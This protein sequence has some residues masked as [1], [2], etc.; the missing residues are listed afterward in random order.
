MAALTSA[1]K[2]II[3]VS[4]LP[5]SGTSLMM[6]ILQVAKTPLL[7]D[8]KRGPDAS[9][10]RG[11]FEF[12]A[13]RRTREDAGWVEG[14][15]G[16]AVKVVHPLLAELPG[17]HFY[18]VILM[19]RPIE[20]IVA[21]QNRMLERLGEPPTNLENQRL[22]AIFCDQLRAARQCLQDRPHFDWIEIDYPDL[23]ADPVPALDRLIDF[24]A[25]P[26][27]ARKLIGVIDPQLQHEVAGGKRSDA[28]FR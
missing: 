18:R 27:K 25:L 5:R 3:V 23:L 19:T 4:G 7:C 8:G 1:P 26:C 24:L 22:I 20:A 16:Y 11:Y 28:P 14:A 9:N 15:P 17:H 6:N 21:S 2:S 13:V 10:P 12:E